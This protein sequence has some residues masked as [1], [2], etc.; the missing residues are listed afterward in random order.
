MHIDRIHSYY[1]TMIGKHK[2]EAFFIKEMLE[3]QD[4]VSHFAGFM[5]T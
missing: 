1:G 2:G 3:I 5:R 4:L